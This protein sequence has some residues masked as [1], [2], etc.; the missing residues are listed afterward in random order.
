[1][2]EGQSVRKFADMRVKAG[3]AAT[4]RQKVS[5]AIRESSNSVS[6]CFIKCTKL[7]EK[8]STK[9]SVFN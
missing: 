1:M 4:V 5:E 6:Q 9:L 2:M 7:A 8:Y 3:T